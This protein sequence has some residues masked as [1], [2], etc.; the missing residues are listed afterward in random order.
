MNM[1]LTILIFIIICIMVG[2]SPSQT[3]I[4]TDPAEI[5]IAPHSTQEKDHQQPQQKQPQ[6]LK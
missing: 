6:L 5:S 2:C 3:G 1:K 4:V